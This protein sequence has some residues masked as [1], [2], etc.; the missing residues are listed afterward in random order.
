MTDAIDR[1]KLKRTLKDEAFW[2][3][4]LPLIASIHPVTRDFLQARWELALVLIGYL[5]H[6]GYLRGRVVRSAGDVMVQ[7]QPIVLPPEMYEA[8]PEE[9]AEDA[10]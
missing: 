2:I 3:A 7:Q 1:L 4:V 8:I 6:N 9:G 5:V 10:V